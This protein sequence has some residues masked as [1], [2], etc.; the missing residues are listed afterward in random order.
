MLSV[1]G[2]PLIE[3]LR[4]QTTSIKTPVLARFLGDQASPS[5]RQNTSKIML[6]WDFIV[7]TYCLGC[8]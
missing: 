3:R 6:P 1:D 2:K 7:T 4:A 5:G 8:T